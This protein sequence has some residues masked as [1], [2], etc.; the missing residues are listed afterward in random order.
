VPS[1]S[2][3]TPQ[4][5]PWRVYEDNV[6]RTSGECILEFGRNLL[7]STALQFVAKP[8]TINILEKDPHT[9]GVFNNKLN[10]YVPYN[11]QSIDIT[12]QS[13]AG[14]SSR[15]GGFG[16]FGSDSGNFGG[17]RFT[18]TY[19]NYNN[20]FNNNQSSN[21]L[22][23]TS[24][25][26]GVSSNGGNFKM[27]GNI[28]FSSMHRG[29]NFGSTNI[30]FN[31]SKGSSGS[32]LNLTSQFNQPSLYDQVRMGTQGIDSSQNNSAVTLHNLCSMAILQNTAPKTLNNAAVKLAIAVAMQ[33]VRQEVAIGV[34]ST[35]TGAILA[36]KGI[37]DTKNILNKKTGLGS[38]TGMPD[39]DDEDPRKKNCNK[40]E[41]PVWKN[42]EN[43][44]GQYRR[45][46]EGTEIYKWDY[47]HN[48]IEVFQPKTGKHLG[49]RDPITGIKIKDG[50]PGRIEH[51]VK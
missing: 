39:P 36:K 16:N 12:V 29:M 24:F 48:E 38:T 21:S 30:G 8:T 44:K 7:Y 14:N 50:V 6:K 5:N 41:S 19:D 11:L 9:Y 49:V 28:N 45:N 18:S 47:T 2:I 40:S 13:Y 33:K 4:H 23:V 34:T 22:K 1:C 43:F 10:V 17:G 37:E 32:E 3:I 27:D 35:V 42:A 31:Y 51:G 15:G 46:K 20:R 26:F 25:D